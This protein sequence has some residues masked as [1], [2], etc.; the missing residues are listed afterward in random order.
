MNNKLKIELFNNLKSKQI[1]LLPPPPSP[2][3]DNNYQDFKI[4]INLLS[5]RI[6]SSKIY[7]NII[8]PP[9]PPPPPSPID[10]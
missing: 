3:L 1:L 2:I 6:I 10:K 8:Y 5:K 7:D 4:N 9:P